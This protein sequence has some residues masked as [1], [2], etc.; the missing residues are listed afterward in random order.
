MQAAATP[1]GREY[2]DTTQGRDRKPERRPPTHYEILQVAPNAH[3]RVIEKA[4]K[5]LVTLYHPDR[6]APENRRECEEIM[7]LINLSY[8]LLSD[9]QK[10]KEYDATL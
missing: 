9:S 1:S 7:K 3:P 2:W 5:V 10:R 6:A 4:Y 8:E